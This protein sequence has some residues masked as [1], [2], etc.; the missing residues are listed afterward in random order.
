MRRAARVAAQEQRESVDFLAVRRKED[1]SN[2]K[3]PHTLRARAQ[4]FFQ[5]RDQTRNETRPECDMILAHRIAQFDRS[6]RK[7]RP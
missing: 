4:I 5:G 7:A 2:F 6:A 1:A 3:E